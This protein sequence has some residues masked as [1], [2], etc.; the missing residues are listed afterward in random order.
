MFNFVIIE[1]LKIDVN[2]CM[3]N[4]CGMNA[5]CINTIGSYDCRCQEGFNGNPFMMCM[6]ALPE[7][8]PVEPVVTDPC[9]G[10]TCGPNSACRSGQCECLPGFSG[11]PCAAPGCRNDLDCPTSD[12]CLPMDYGTKSKPRTCVAACSREQCGPNAA[13]VAENH[14]ASCICRD[15][16]L[17]N[18]YNL[19]DGCQPEA[20]VDKCGRDEDCPGETICGRNI[21]GVKTCVDPCLSF[22]CGQS[23]IC[24]NKGGKAH[25]ECLTSF[26]RNPV[27]GLCEKPGSKSHALFE[28]RAIVQN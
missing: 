22:T 10:V 2:E 27:N 11:E 18:A 9:S 17:G 4:A 14:R 28:I 3:G 23:E 15:G 25:C 21:D 16:F 1:F 13:C 20:A 6:P 26:I 8:R 19:I 7:A 12:I 24:V 5:V